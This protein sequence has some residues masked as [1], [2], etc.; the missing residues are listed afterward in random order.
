MNTYAKKSL[1]QNFLVDTNIIKKIISLTNIFDKNILEIG[2]GKGALTDE[3]LK[4]KPKSLILIEKDNSLSNELKLKYKDN[5]KITI[6]NKDVL[7]FNFEKKLEKDTIILGNLPYNIASQILVN[8]IKFKKWPP[9]YSNLIFMFQ[10]EMAERIMGKYGTSKYGRLSVLT[11][12]RLKVIN[13]FKVSPN[14]F[15]PKP[16]IDSTVLLFKPNSKIK[17]KIK[18]IENLEKITHAF[19]SKRRKMINKTFSKLFENSQALSKKLDINLSLRPSQLQ[20]KDF[21]KIVEYYE[22]HKKI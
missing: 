15:F 5:K 17:S 14:C 11:N 4:N 13:K 3:I 21:Y 1:G 20:E 19:F 8:I 2:P 6:Y 9:K 12:F 10:K 16:K 7:K 18:N 22:K